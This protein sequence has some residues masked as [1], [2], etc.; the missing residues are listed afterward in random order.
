MGTEQKPLYLI[1]LKLDFLEAISRLP[2]AFIFMIIGNCISILFL[3]LKQTIFE[4]IFFFWYFK[5][6]TGSLLGGIFFL[7]GFIM[8]FRSIRKFVIIFQPFESKI[9]MIIQMMTIGSFVMFFIEFIFLFIA[10]ELLLF[11]AYFYLTLGFS[12]LF[13]II[14][15]G[16]FISLSIFFSKSKIINGMNSRLL[17]LPLVGIPFVLFKFLTSIFSM[18]FWTNIWEYLDFS[19]SLCY[20]LI[21]ASIYIEIIYAFGKINAKQVFTYLYPR[22]AITNEKSEFKNI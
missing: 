11:D 6:D 16:V 1:D 15:I 19:A 8:F 17:I 18:I 10:F 4:G 21:Y 14:I 12:I 20:N 7:I 13:E 5:I 9:L 2:T 22:N 3:I